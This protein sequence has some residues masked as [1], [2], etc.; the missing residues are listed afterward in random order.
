MRLGKQ[1]RWPVCLDSWGRLGC[2]SGSWPS[3]GH[4]SCLRSDPTDR[5]PSSFPPLLLLRQVNKSRKILHPCID[6][7]WL[8]NPRKPQRPQGPRGRSRQS[9]GT[10]VTPSP[11]PA[12]LPAHCTLPSRA[13]GAPKGGGCLQPGPWV[14]GASA[15]SSGGAAVRVLFTEACR[16]SVAWEEKVP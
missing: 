6:C 15:V 10:T 8:R 14:A 4:C 2:S 3:P 16:S 5:R 1:H 7:T 12:R 9:M 13:P 11:A